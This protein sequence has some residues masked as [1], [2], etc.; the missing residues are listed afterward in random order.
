MSNLQ[1]IFITSNHIKHLE[2]LIKEA[3]L[4]DKI[5]LRQILSGEK[6]HL[7]RLTDKMFEKVA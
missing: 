4:E 7:K 3:P 5:K 6:E 2:G 1:Q